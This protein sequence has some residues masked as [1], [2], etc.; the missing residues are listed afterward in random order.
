M[1]GLDAFFQPRIAELASA[2]TSVESAVI[3]VT[4]DGVTCTTYAD[5]LDQLNAGENID[6]DGVSGQIQLDDNGDPTFARFTTAKL[7]GGAVANIAS[8]DVNIADIRRQQEAHAAATLNTQIQQAL[9]FL[10]FH[11]GPIDGICTQEVTD[12]VKALQRDLG[13]P[14]TG[15]LDE[16]TLQAAYSRGV[17]TGSTNEAITAGLDTD[18]FAALL[19]ED[20]VVLDALLAYH[21]VENV[22]LTTDKPTGDPGTINGAVLPV[23]GTGASLT[24]GGAS[25]TVPDGVA[26]NGVVDEMGA[27]SVIPR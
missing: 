24:V 23:L 20:P 26:S 13:V 16:A 10:G 5:C 3:D 12:A 9:T 4:G 1:I 27:V 18:A 8:T 6:Y 19:A 25:I 15:V 11:T 7:E 21:V 14:E 22:R 17:S 2:A